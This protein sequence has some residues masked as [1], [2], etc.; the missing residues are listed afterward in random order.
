M[1]LTVAERRAAGQMSSKRKVGSCT[2][3][4]RSSVFVLLAMFAA[5]EPY[6][7]AMSGYLPPLI[8]VSTFCSAK[9]AFP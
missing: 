6:R 5:H 2:R 9:S 4:A 3:F 7:Y 1:P 8:A